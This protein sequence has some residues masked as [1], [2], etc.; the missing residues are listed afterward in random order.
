MLWS[1]LLKRYLTRNLLTGIFQGGSRTKI[2]ACMCFHPKF[3][4]SLGVSCTSLS[5]SLWMID[6]HVLFLQILLE[7][8]IFILLPVALLKIS[9][10][11]NYFPSYFDCLIFGKIVLIA[12]GPF[13]LSFLI[14]QFSVS[15]THNS[16]MVGPIAKRLFGQTITLFP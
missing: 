16:K 15:I 4:I 10:R 6:W 7:A 5:R 2:V 3:M 13:G 14:T 8:F 9:C 1:C 12:Q 11:K